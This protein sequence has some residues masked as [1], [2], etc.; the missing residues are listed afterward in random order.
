MKRPDQNNVSSQSSDQAT[1]RGAPLA[2]LVVSDRA[3]W[4][5][6]K[7][8]NN[9]A[10]YLIAQRYLDSLVQIAQNADKTVFLPYEASGVMGAL[11]GI[12]E[13]VGASAPSPVKA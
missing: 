9:P 13:L 6:R 3:S 11:G 2:F 8:F 1:D 12:K 7:A 4:I 5:Y 10:Q